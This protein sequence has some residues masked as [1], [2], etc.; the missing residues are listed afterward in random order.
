MEFKILEKIMGFDKEKAIQNATI[1]GIVDIGKLIACNDFETIKEGLTNYP[2]TISE[3]LEKLNREGNKRKIFEYAVDHG[4]TNAANWCCKQTKNSLLEAATIDIYEQKR[5]NNSI[6]FINDDYFYT[7][8][9]WRYGLYSK[10]TKTHEE[11]REKIL[12][13]LSLKIDKQTITKGL[14]ENYFK[15]LLDSGNIEMLIIKLCVRLE[16]ILKCDF[17]YEG[18]FEEM[19]SNYSKDTQQYDDWNGQY[20]CS[21]ESITFNELRKC[22]NN[23]VHAQKSDMEMSKEDLEKAIEY[24]CKLG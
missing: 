5:R 8:A 21:K 19:L 16:A 1:D 9:N 11:V 18:T 17:H 2:L 14:T 24:V 6:K 20:N 3:Y 10:P 22:R 13:E 4:L 12:K 23:I 7:D 15:D